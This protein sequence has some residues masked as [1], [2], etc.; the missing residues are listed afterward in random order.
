MRRDMLSTLGGDDEGDIRF[1]ISIPE[2]DAEKEALK[3]ESELE[4]QMDWD[5]VGSGTKRVL[6][7]NVSSRF[8]LRTAPLSRAENRPHLS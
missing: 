4:K 5:E 8:P 6:A 2:R 3:E 1:S 7:M